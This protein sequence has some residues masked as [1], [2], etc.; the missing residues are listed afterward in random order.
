[1][2][3]ITEIST[4]L[5]TQD[6]RITYDPMF[7]VQEKRIVYGMDPQWSDD[8]LWIDTSGGV[9]ECDAPADGLETETIVKTGKFEYWEIQMVAFT[10]VGCQQYIDLNGHNHRGELRIYAMSFRRCPEM[11][12]VRKFLLSQTP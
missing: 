10:E 2:N 3:E 8:E 11:L 1:M 6:N 9:I 4:R 5:K 7:C 12:E